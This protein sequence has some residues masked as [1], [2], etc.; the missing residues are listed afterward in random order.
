[1]FLSSGA[2]SMSL[3]KETVAGKFENGTDL[4]LPA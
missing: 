2:W 1:M 4:F 3:N